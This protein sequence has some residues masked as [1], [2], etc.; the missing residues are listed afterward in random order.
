MIDEIFSLIWTPVWG[1]YLQDAKYKLQFAKVIRLF[2]VER[3]KVQQDSST[4]NRVLL[5]DLVKQLQGSDADCN[6]I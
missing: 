4:I 6:G 3:K 1:V 2:S 5:D